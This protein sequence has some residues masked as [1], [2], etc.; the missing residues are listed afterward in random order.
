MQC[1]QAFEEYPGIK[2][3]HSCTGSSKKANDILRQQFITAKYG[4][5]TESINTPR[6]VAKLGLESN[7]QSDYGDQEEQ[8]W[9]E[10]SRHCIQTERICHAIGFG[11]PATSH[12]NAQCQNHQQRAAD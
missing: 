8:A 7:H 11:P 2:W 6:P 4:T 3:A 9:V 5:A 12:N 1:F 10:P